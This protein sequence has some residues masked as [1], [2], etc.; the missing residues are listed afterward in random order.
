MVAEIRPAA[1]KDAAPITAVFLA[2]PSATIPYLPRLY[3]DE[4]TGA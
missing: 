1:A 3:D 2:S 4:Q